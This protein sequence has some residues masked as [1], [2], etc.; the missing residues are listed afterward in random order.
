ME[1][2]RVQYR[3]D[4]SKSAVVSAEETINTKKIRLLEYG[5]S[6]EDAFRLDWL[7]AVKF[8]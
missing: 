3:A 7:V 2:C 6:N 1:R 8:E 4:V 5:V